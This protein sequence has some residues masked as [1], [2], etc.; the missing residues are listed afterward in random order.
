MTN[1]VSVKDRLKN[2]A[3]TNGKTMQEILTAY[4]YMHFLMAN[5]RELL[6]ILIFWRRTYRTIQKR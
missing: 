3:S 1:A 4:S 2:H 5:L 6:G